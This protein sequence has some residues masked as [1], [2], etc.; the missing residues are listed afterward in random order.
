MAEDQA[1]QAQ[2][3]MVNL[4]IEQSRLPKFFGQQEKDTVTALY[5]IN[6]INDLSA[7]NNWSPEVAFSHFA[8]CV[9]GSASEWLTSQIDVAGSQKTWTWIEPRFRLE[10]MTDDNDCLLLDQL[11]K[12][13]MRPNEKLRDYFS[14]INKL[15]RLLESSNKTSI[16]LVPPMN[17]ETY[18]P[19][20]V[21][22]LLS[23]QRRQVYDHTQLI[24]FN[25]GLPQ[26]IKSVVIQHKITNPDQAYS[27]ARDQYQLIEKKKSL[28]AVSEAP[29]ATPPEVEPIRPKFRPH[30][31]QNKGFQATQ[32]RFQGN[33]RPNRPQYQKYGNQQMN[34]QAKNNQMRNGITCTFCHFNGHHQDDCRRRMEANKPC[35][36]PSGKTYWPKSRL[37]PVETQEEISQIRKT[38]I[39]SMDFH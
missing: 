38:N 14:R 31:Q 12:T 21:R 2:V 27:I 33:F 37:Q 29:E 6:R 7:A 9:E 30:F 1:N 18:T 10:F 13:E 15:I 20:E 4:K 24:I 25:A 11:K 26:E 28:L 22:Q 16:E 39:C 36:A 17:G 32:P 19:E 5:L 3:H 23:K 8:M 35:I 34:Y